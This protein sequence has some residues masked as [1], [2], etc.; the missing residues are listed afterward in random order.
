[1]IDD[2]PEALAE[3]VAYGNWWHGHHDT[4][5]GFV[6]RSGVHQA[7]LNASAAALTQ[8]NRLGYDAHLVDFDQPET[9]TPDEELALGMLRWN[10]AILFGTE[11]YYSILS[12]WNFGVGGWPYRAPDGSVWHLQARIDSPSTVGVY[13][14]VLRIDVTAPSVLL[15]TFTVPTTGSA[16]LGW[17]QSWDEGGVSGITVNFN[18]KTGA[19]AAAHRYGWY[20]LPVWIL[21]FAISGGSFTSVPTIAGTV[22]FDAATSVSTTVQDDQWVDESHIEFVRGAD[23]EDY[24]LD[25]SA[26]VADISNIVAGHDPLPDPNGSDYLTGDLAYRYYASSTVST[27]SSYGQTHADGSTSGSVL[28]QVVGV[29]YGRGGDRRVMAIE[30]EE[31][32]TWGDTGYHV[33]DLGWYHYHVKKGVSPTATPWY[34]D[35]YPVSPFAIDYPAY[36]RA[37]TSDVFTSLRFVANGEILC[38]IESHVI[39]TTTAEQ[40]ASTLVTDSTVMT[41]SGNRYNGAVDT[42]HDLRVPGD[43]SQ[44][45]RTRIMLPAANVF[46]YCDYRLANQYPFVSRILMYAAPDEGQVFGWP[47]PWDQSTYAVPIAVDPVTGE[48]SK[49]TLRYF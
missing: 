22:T 49:T 24:R 47:T 1:M 33:G 42:A 8:K 17:A 39:T 35:G 11:K 38:A 36:T 28:R 6:S 25:L 5:D 21:E 20:K 18:P 26:F 46:A 4:V 31:T 2:A 43:I 40:T 10:K 27:S 7:T 45:D 16:D 3:V 19:Q 37:K 48:F 34:C 44:T 12:A 13:G 30:Y 23:I 41:F 29:A 15:A 9:T 32:T 14:N